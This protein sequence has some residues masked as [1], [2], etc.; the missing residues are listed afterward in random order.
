MMHPSD[1]LEARLRQDAEAVRRAAQ[2][3]PPI[4]HLIMGR[5]A[6]SAPTSSVRWGSRAPAQLLLAVLLTL[7]AVGVFLFRHGSP[8]PTENPP[9]APSAATPIETAQFLN[10]QEGVVVTQRGLL[11][12]R[13][14]GQTWQLTL[15]LDW[16]S[17]QDI[18]FVDP[19]H[20]IVVSSSDVRPPGEPV[21]LFLYTTA[22]GGAHWHTSSIAPITVGTAR[23]P[24]FLNDHEGWELAFSGDNPANPTM[25]ALYHTTDGGAH[26]TQL[27]TVDASQPSSG[28]LQLASA[29]D[30]LFFTDSAHGFMGTASHD[31]VGRLFVTRDGGRTWRAAIL[32]APWFQ[33]GVGQDVFT[34]ASAVTMFGDTGFLTQAGGPRV[35]VYATYDGGLTWGSPRLLPF[36]K[37]RAYFLDRTHWWVTGEGTLYETVDG[38]ASWQR[39]P[40]VPVDIW[41]YLEALSAN[42][43]Q[44]FWGELIQSS[45]P[46]DS[47]IAGVPPSTCFPSPYGPDCS[48]LVRSIDGGHHWTDVKLPG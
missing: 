35:A 13:D 29:P 28:G 7:A 41:P 21:S 42:G 38:G 48:F 34:L 14:G 27:H 25:A 46:G 20:I 45:I 11:I 12:T 40:D 39:L 31:N 8:S 37:G 33:G 47:P 16:H 30:D 22:D 6:S 36:Q 19:E 32:P 15:K 23:S 44:V 26:W 17:Y 9:T 1:D 4:H 2:Q 5:L 3:D 43:P 24:F 10:P 18:R